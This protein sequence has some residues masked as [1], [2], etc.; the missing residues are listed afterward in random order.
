MFEC[1]DNQ[2]VGLEAAIL[3]RVRNSSL[4]LISLSLRPTGH[5][6]SFQPRSVRSSTRTYPRFNLPMGSSLSFGSTARDY[7]ALFGLAFVTPALTAFPRVDRV[8]TVPT[9]ETARAHE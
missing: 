5:P 3:E 8:T 2:E 6:P 1:T 7:D 9:R 4:S